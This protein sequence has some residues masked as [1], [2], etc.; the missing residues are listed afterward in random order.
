MY[1]PSAKGEAG[2]TL[3]ACLEKLLGPAI[4]EILVNPSLRHSSAILSSPRSLI[5][6]I[7]TFS[8][9]KYCRRTAR[10]ARSDHR[11]S[12]HYRAGVSRAYRRELTWRLTLPP[13]WSKQQRP[14]GV[15]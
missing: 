8:S 3:P 11:R 13:N 2:Q 1:V 15:A 14:L 5:I 10:L 4:I 7:L 12:D 6:T 9:A